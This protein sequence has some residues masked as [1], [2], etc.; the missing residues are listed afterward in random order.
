MRSIIYMTSGMKFS[1]DEPATDS[2]ILT[3][4]HD[5]SFKSDSPISIKDYLG[6]TTHIIYLA[7][8]EFIEFI[9]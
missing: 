4:D 9:Y 6:R 2:L 1:L 7:N 8:I 5:N 3:M